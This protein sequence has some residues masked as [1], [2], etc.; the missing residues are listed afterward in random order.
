MKNKLKYKGDLLIL[1][2][3]FLWSFLG[4][5][6][7]TVS[8]HGMTVAGITSLMAV[9]V[10]LAFYGKKALVLNRLT[11]F[12][13][14]VTALMNLT[15]LLANKYTTVANAIVLQY[16][17]P[18]FVVLYYRIF[19]HRKLQKVQL[20][21]VA[22]CFIGLLIFFADQLGS[23][24]MFGNLLALVSG[25]LFAGSFYLNALPENNPTS[26]HFFSNVI[27]TVTGLAYTFLCTRQT[28]EF[29]QT[30]LLL[31]AGIFCSGIAAVM[32]SQGIRYTTALNANLIAMSEVLMAPIWALLFF[33][34]TVSAPAGLGAGMMILSILY[35]TWFESR[36][37]A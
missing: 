3:A 32:Y 24:N 21:T 30:A 16:S 11:L 27:C 7:K 12:T 20:G 4:I 13:A 1:G 18:I 34:E 31:T 28:Y 29:P 8:Y 19:Q 6:T 14:T 35:E 26:S 5:I 36:C 2:T 25:I 15:F 23:G 17:S 22:V 10:L 9:L 37:E 33:G